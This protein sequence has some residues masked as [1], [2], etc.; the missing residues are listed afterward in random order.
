MRDL[1]RFSPEDLRVEQDR[2][3]MQLFELCS[4]AADL[5]RRMICVP[6]AEGDIYRAMHQRW[7]LKIAEAQ[8][9]GN[10]ILKITAELERRAQA[11]KAAS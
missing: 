4:D 2:A 8:R 10:L 1:S 9:W 7:E 6:A 5:T 11:S 3:L